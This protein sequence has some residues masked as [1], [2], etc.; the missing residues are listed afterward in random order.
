MMIIMSGE[1][2]LGLHRSTKSMKSTRPKIFQALKLSSGYQKLNMHI[3]SLLLDAYMLHLD[4]RK[5]NMS[6]LRMP[7]IY[8]PK[9][10]SKYLIQKSSRMVYQELI[11]QIS[12][13]MKE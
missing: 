4:L 3:M 12:R 1:S 9:K 5:M 6:S 11:L 10:N 2:I 13:I 8:S 7:G